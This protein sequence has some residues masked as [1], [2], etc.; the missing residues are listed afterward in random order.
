MMSLERRIPN[1]CISRVFEEA[2][3]ALAPNVV[4]GVFMFH[5]PN[6]LDR[7]RLL[8]EPQLPSAEALEQWWPEPEREKF[9][10]LVPF[11]GARPREASGALGTRREVP[12]ANRSSDMQSFLPRP[13]TS[14]IRPASMRHIASEPS[15]DYRRPSISAPAQQQPS[16][17]AEAPRGAAHPAPSGERPLCALW[18][19]SRAPPCA[20]P[21]TRWGRGRGMCSASRPRWSVL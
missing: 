10:I 6:A 7:R 8:D 11:G 21:L 19:L 16:P 17:E 13:M 9:S 15:L 2:C 12:P 4:T 20:L 1:R 18:A 3:S 14:F 5:G